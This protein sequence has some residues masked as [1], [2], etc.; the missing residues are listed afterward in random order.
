MRVQ[1]GVSLIVVGFIL[2]IIGFFIIRKF[3]KDKR[4]NRSEE[5]FTKEGH[6]R[7]EVL[8][9]GTTIPIDSHSQIKQSLN[10]TSIM[11]NQNN[12]FQFSY[13]TEEILMRKL[14]NPWENLLDQPNEETIIQLKKGSL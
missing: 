1:L 12:N 14:K 6:S 13:L 7:I 3:L 8:K 11:S 2:P 10:N 4:K 9:E 5:I